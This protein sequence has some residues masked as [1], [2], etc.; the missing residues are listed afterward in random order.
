[1]KDTKTMT[2]VQ[3]S[4]IVALDNYKNFALA[5]EKCFVTQPTL[6]M[7][8]Q[9]LEEEL[10]ILI[11]DRSKQ[12]AQ[13]TQLGRKVIDQA[14]TVLDETFRINEIISDESSEISG[15]FTL[16][17]IPTIG[18]NLLPLFIENFVKKHEKLELVIEELQTDQIIKK[19]RSDELDAGILMTPLYTKD[20]TE[21]ILFYEPFVGYV[22]K[23]HRLWRRKKINAEE[24]SLSDLFLL[25]EGH[26]FRDNVIQI[27][28]RYSIKN[29][30][31]KKNL[32]FEGG[33][34]ETLR[35]M[36]ENNFGMTLL[37]YL[38]LKD[39]KNSDK[40]KFIR[41][42]E[43]P[44]PFREISL[45]FRRTYS[46]RKTKNAITKEIRLVIPKKYHTRPKGFV[47]N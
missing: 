7:Q 45:V 19:L 27:C 2:N 15:T 40:V 10:G 28:E 34:L 47:V 24:L 31:E 35:K 23:S 12:P 39:L 46:K 6:S 11:F 1:M 25:K 4:Y 33:S 43:E 44:I 5:A 26:C 13:A 30:E 8:I 14:K 9:K 16:G 32:N 29:K 3:L 36:V 18:P 17:I 38:S 37:P 22:S 41:K 21:E 42:F 20:I